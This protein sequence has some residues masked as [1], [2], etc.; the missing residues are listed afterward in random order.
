MEANGDFAIGVNRNGSTPHVRRMLF[1]LSLN[2]LLEI[3]QSKDCKSLRF[4]SS[5]LL[6]TAFPLDFQGDLLSHRRHPMWS[7]LQN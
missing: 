7:S 6:C 1:T 5:E 3:C 2:S 4:L